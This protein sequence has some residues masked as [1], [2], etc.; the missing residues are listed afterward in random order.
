MIVIAILLTLTLPLGSMVIFELFAGRSAV[1]LGSWRLELVGTFPDVRRP[2]FTI[3]DWLNR[4]FQDSAST[5]F[6]RYFG[7]R[8]LF[9]K[10]G[11][12]VNYSLFG[13]SYMNNQS[14]I[15]GKQ[16]QLYEAPYV[17]DYCKLVRPMS[18]ELAE[19]R[20]KEIAEAFGAYVVDGS[21]K[22]V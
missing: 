1:A 3:Q 12:Q 14:I 17:N 9:V 15:I 20:V 6:S 8:G 5:W 10:L 4:R 16:N 22:P 13:T 11:N 7:A 21:K 19:A 2:D 18:L